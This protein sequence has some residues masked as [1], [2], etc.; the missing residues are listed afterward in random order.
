MEVEKIKEKIDKVID[1]IYDFVRY[2]PKD[3]LELTMY[4]YTAKN[5]AESYDELIGTP[6]GRENYIVA[7]LIE[8]YL[9]EYPFYKD[10]HK[11]S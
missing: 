2:Q 9:R 7:N 6:I 4:L 10:S 11:E 8:D 3:D 5:I 1:E